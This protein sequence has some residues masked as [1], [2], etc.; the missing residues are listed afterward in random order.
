LLLLLYRQLPLL[1]HSRLSFGWV[2]VPVGRV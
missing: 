2:K 1:H